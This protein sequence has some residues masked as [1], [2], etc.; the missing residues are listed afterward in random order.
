[1]SFEGN[2]DFLGGKWSEVALLSRTSSFHPFPHLQFKILCQRLDVLL[3]E[4]ND[5]HLQWH[6]HSTFIIA[7]QLLKSCLKPWKA[8]VSWNISWFVPK[9]MNHCCADSPISQT[10]CFLSLIYTNLMENRANFQIRWWIRAAE[11]D[12]ER[13]VLELVDITRIGGRPGDTCVRFGRHLEKLVRGDWLQ[14]LSHD[15]MWF[16]PNTHPTS[17]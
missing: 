8:S 16:V 15:E 17:M 7:I 10:P 5:F 11:T 12:V 2:W 4:F 13:S 9:W 3:T 1:M 6:H 14:Q